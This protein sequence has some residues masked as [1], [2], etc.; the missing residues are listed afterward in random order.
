MC[1]GGRQQRSR[2]FSQSHDGTKMKKF[3]NKKLIKN[4]PEICLIAGPSDRHCHVF[5]HF[6]H[7]LSFTFKQES[8]LNA[9]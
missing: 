8:L 6:E 7:N 5:N 3:F 1:E 4:R 2:H 9:R